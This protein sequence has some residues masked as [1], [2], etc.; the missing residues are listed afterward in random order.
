MG[1]S[2]AQ[3]TRYLRLARGREAER[4][5]LD[6]VVANHAFA[7]GERAR[8]LLTSLHRKADGAEA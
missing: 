4:R 3:F 7:G 1:Y 5:A 6:L 8:Q 2:W